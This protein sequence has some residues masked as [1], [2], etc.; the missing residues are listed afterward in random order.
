MEPR[1]QLVLGFDL[2][3]AAI[4]G[5]HDLQAAWDDAMDISIRSAQPLPHVYGGAIAFLLVSV[6]AL[7]EVDLL[8][9]THPPKPRDDFIHSGPAGRQ[10]SV[11]AGLEANDA[12]EIDALAT[13]MVTALLP[14]RKRLS[15]SGRLARVPKRAD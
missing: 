9:E 14:N 5:D 2:M 12:A 10:A 1:L 11:Y 13:A 7:E 6:A 15:F 4:E 8:E 3:R